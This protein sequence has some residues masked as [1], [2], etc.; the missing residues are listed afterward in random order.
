MRFESCVYFVVGGGGS[1]ADAGAQRW[2]ALLHGSTTDWCSSKAAHQSVVLPCA[3]AQGRWCA[4]WGRTGRAGVV[5]VLGLCRI[6]DEAAPA[7]MAG[8]EQRSSNDNGHDRR[9][10]RLLVW[11]DQ[12]EQG[13]GRPR[14]HL[15]PKR[16]A[17]CALLLGGG[18]RRRRRRWQST[19]A[20]RWILWAHGPQRG[21]D[22]VEGT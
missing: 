5:A 16:A 14:A 11:P 19:A 20:R 8:L 9:R 15:V 3:S 12:A 1:S 2:L 10:T 17:A 6:P 22:G 21:H 18:G 4:L 7:P 13:A